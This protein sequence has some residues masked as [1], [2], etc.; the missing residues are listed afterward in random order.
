MGKTIT[1]L[2]AP[3]KAERLIRLAPYCRVSSDSEDQQHSFAAQVKYYTEYTSSHPEYALVDIY[4]DEGVTGTRMDKRSD[5]SRLIRDCR[6]GKIDRII[7]KSVSRFARNTTELLTAVRM[8]KA[9]GVSIY[10]EEQGIDTETIDLEMILT[11]PGI[12]AQ[13]ESETISENMRWSYQKR[14]ESGEFNCCRAA[15]GYDL[16][17]GQLRINETEAEVVR[18]I[19]SLY[20]QGYGK[21][22]IA[23]ILNEDSVPKRYGNKTWHLHGVSYILGNERYMGDALL[24][25][26]YTTDTLPFRKKRN[27]GEKARY[28]VENSNPPIVSRET[29]QAAQALQK[30]RATGNQTSK[31]RYPFSGV[32]KCPVCG[33][34]YRRQIVNGT[35]YWLC[36][37]KA[38]GRTQCDSK[39]IR[40]DEAMAAFTRMSGK[41]VRNREEVLGDLIR[42]LEK[43]QARTSGSSGQIYQLDKQSADVN[44]QSLVVAKLHSSGILNNAEYAAQ[45]GE[46]SRKVS[47]LRSERRRI[48][49]EDEDDEIIES[50][51]SLGSVLAEYTPTAAFDEEL[52]GQIVESVTVVSRTTL[53]FC[54]AGGLALTENL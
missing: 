45:S 20:L 7:T 13:R 48:L 6:K 16:I 1:E 14:M 8:L 9:I 26:S 2:T 50:L 21:Q 36:S 12:T 15:Y 5:F 39:R 51:K 17:D 53:R 22:A 28:Y 38:S 35:A 47:S 43:L 37:Y 31:S 11:F 27:H 32:L 18:R 34:T 41:L 44:A 24:Q 54:L 46:L 40:E 19:F 33:H 42:Q 30:S 23:N 3:K 52:F 10:F 25:K 29:F 49:M 4:A